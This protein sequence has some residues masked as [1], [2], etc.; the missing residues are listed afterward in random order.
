MMAF[1]YAN[2]WFRISVE[3]FGMR[4]KPALRKYTI[5]CAKASRQVK[6]QIVRR[7]S[8]QVKARAR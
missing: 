6:Q 2:C 7:I 5:D 3:F 1:E 4:R 8:A